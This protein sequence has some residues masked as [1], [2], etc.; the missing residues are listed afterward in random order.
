MP[1]TVKGFESDAIRTCRMLTDI[2]VEKGNPY[3]KSVDGIVYTLDGKRLIV[4]PEGKKGSV[5]V[6]NGTE[7]IWR[8]A[9]CYCE[10]LT[11]VAFPDSLKVIEEYA[12]RE[13]HNLTRLDLPNSVKTIGNYAFAWCYNLSEVKLSDSLELIEYSAFIDC[14]RITSV[15]LPDSIIS[16]EFDA[17]NNCDSLKEV[18][19]GTSLEN[20]AQSAFR[21]CYSLSEITVSENNK[22]YASQNG[23]V[24][25]KDKTNFYIVPAGISGEITIPASVK[26]F[27]YEA[28]ESCNK[29]TAI[30]VETGNM[31]YKSVDGVVYTADGKEL[32]VCPKAKEGTVVVAD[33]TERIRCYAFYDCDRVKSIVLP[34]SI[35]FIDEHAISNCDNLRSIN[36]P[37][38]IRTIGWYGL[39]HNWNLETINIP[40]SITRLNNYIFAGCGFTELTLPS[41]VQSFNHTNWSRLKNFT[42][43]NRYCEYTSTQAPELNSDCT[44]RAYCGSLGHTF[45]TKRLLKFESIGHTYLD[46]YI[47]KPATFEE[48][49]IERRDCAYCK[50]YDE[51]VIPK[52]ENEVYTATFLADGKVVATVE[53]SKGTTSLENEPKVPVK[54]RYIGQWEDYTLANADITINA[55]YTLIKSDDASEIESSSE[56]IHYGDKD[57]V[58]FRLRA[59]AD[60]LVVKST[61]SQAVPLDIVL[62]VDQSGSMAETLG[63]KTKKVDALMDAAKAF[64]E[65]VFENSEITGAD[66]RVSLVGFG[67]SGNWQGYEKNENTELLTSDRGIVKFDD[68]KTSDYA[69][70]LMNVNVNGSL[71]SNILK[72]IYNIGAKGATAADLGFEMAKGVFANTDSTDRQRVVIF[73]TDGEPTYSSGFD[74]SVANAAIYNAS[75]L[76]NVYDAS[77]Y[78]VGVFTEADSKNTNINKFMN[79]VSSG[80]SDAVS[81]KNMG[82]GVDGQYYVTVNNTDSLTSVFKTIST[83]SLSHTAPF[84]NITFIKTLSEYV[85]M[86]TPQEEQLRIDLIRKY[87][88]TNDDIIVKRNDDGTTTIQINGL[89][90]YETVDENGNVIYEVVVEFFASLNEKAAGKGEYIIVDTEDSGVMLGKDAKA[91]ETLFDTSD[92]YIDY[93]KTR[94]IFTINGEVY[95]IIEW[96][97]KD[98][99][100]PEIEI[101]RDWYFSGWD[102]DVDYDDIYNGL[103]FDATLK[104]IDRKITWHLADGDIVQYYTEGEVIDVPTVGMSEKGEAFL[105]WDKSIPTT[106]PDENLEFYAIYG[107]HVHKYASEEVVKV[108]CET[109]GIMRYTCNCGDTYEKVIEALKHNYEAMTPSLEKEDGK[110]AFC[111]TKCGNKYEYA[112]NFEVIDTAGNKE[113]VVYEFSL[114]DD[115][116]STNIQPE[117]EI[118]IR[119][120]LSEIHGSVAKAIVNRKNEDGTTTQVPAVVEHGF[121]VI[122]CEHFTPYEINFVLPCETHKEVYWVVTKE[123]TCKEAG[124]KSEICTECENVVNTEEIE[125][126][127]CI[128]SDWLIETYPTCCKDGLQYKA[129]S[130][131]GEILKE[132]V[133]EKL[134]PDNTEWRIY[135]EATCYSKGLE[136]EFCTVCQSKLSENEL[137]ELEHVKADWINVQKEATCIEEGIHHIVCVYCEEVLETEIVPKTEHNISGWFVY[138]YPTCDEDGLNARVCKY[139]EEVFESEPIAALG[140]QPSDWIVYEATCEKEGYKYIE[141]KK[142]GDTLNEEYLAITDHKESEWIVEITPSCDKEGKKIKKCVYCSKEL[143]SA[144]IETSGHNATE[145][146]IDVEPTCTSE[147]SKSHHCI[148]CDTKKDVTVIGKLVHTYMTAKIEPTCIKEGYIIYVCNCGDT[149]YETLKTNEHN[150]NGSKC[151]DCGFDK[152]DSCPCNCHKSGIMEIIWK[153]INFFNKFLK[154]NTVCACGKA[155]Y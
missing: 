77:I 109:D 12:F 134:Y 107:L 76:K 98:I 42:I 114:T 95:D 119:I 25:N 148:Y 92:V 41:T 4:C 118:K 85:T 138:I 50:G 91:Y 131:C 27:S 112:L 74:T 147:G 137:P 3:Y 145:W 152:A 57:D 80:Y 7:T 65:T 39:A 144:V 8:E 123:P 151:V 130:G 19:I 5:I 100:T 58:F 21:T 15:D 154:I 49:G 116:L 23:V 142:C 96:D 84:D 132:E 115:D 51:R 29:L 31:N 90:P 88:I 45:A 9:F 87:G 66:H 28:V 141:C 127:S 59:W 60:A 86:T 120:P 125:K 133:I 38:S 68:I 135:K 126:L 14:D 46:W 53:F 111:C 78:S 140:H 81:M 110:C 63:G 79:A 72:A 71:N 155:H 113:R 69:S 17:F 10:D 18:I 82:K 153:I 62:V 124:V 70:S 54:D 1:A 143:D 97:W 40:K 55:V 26:E 48:N 24:Y 146:I 101:G 99:I 117:G 121:L 93:S 33:G 67:L 37:E 52:L 64:V 32:I 47:S 56:V 13:C 36:L 22:Y 136:Q 11:S 6:A 103:T 35:K 149:Y 106:M 94:L 150:F 105:S 89:T 30:H 44:I 83:E 108:T 61:V 104:K 20:L 102:T 122:T 128:E 73:M 43:L 129:C 75:L 34:D 16:I 2:H 139:C